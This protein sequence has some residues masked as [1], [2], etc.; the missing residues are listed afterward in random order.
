[1]S[2]T[3]VILRTVETRQR[4]ADRFCATNTRLFQ[5][6]HIIILRFVLQTKRHIGDGQIEKSSHSLHKRLSPP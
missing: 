4:T 5:T 6:N 2:L 3:G 1:M